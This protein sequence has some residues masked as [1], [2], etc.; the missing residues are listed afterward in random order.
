MSNLVP[1]L[2]GPCGLVS[3]VTLA[4]IC[5][6]WRVTEKTVRAWIER[7]GFPRPACILGRLRFNVAEVNAWF[8]SKRQEGGRATA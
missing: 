8:E 7:E 2:A 3:T 1:D 4:A 6:T 5:R